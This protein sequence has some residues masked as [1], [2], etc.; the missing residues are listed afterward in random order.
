MVKI[1][2]ITSSEKMIFEQDL[3]NYINEIEKE[4]EYEIYYQPLALNKVYYTA[5]VKTRRKGNE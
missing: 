3:E 4:Y 2:V 1:K 5:L